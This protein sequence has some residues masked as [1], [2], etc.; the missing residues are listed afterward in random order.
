MKTKISKK[1][2][3]LIILASPFYLDKGSS[4]RARSN[5]IAWG[6][7]FDNVDLISYPVGKSLK[8]R[9]VN[10]IRAKIPGYKQISAGPSIVKVYADILLFF[11]SIY[12]ILKNKHDLV[13]GEDFEGGFLGKILAI[14]FHKKFIY[15]MYNPL[16]ENIKPYSSKPC[17][18]CVANKVDKF[19]EK[20]T[21]NIAFEWDY[22]K[23]R[24][25]TLYPGKNTVVVQDAFPRE[26][27]LING[28]NGKRYAF[29]AGNFKEYQGIKFFLRSFKLFL[30][31]GGNLDLVLAGAH[32]AETKKYAKDLG[33]L[34]KVNFVGN[35]DL[36]RT[37]Y[38]IKK[39]S[40]CILPR[41]VDG[42]PGI[43]ALH[44][45]SQGKPIL[46]TNLTCNSKMIENTKTGLLVPVSE[47]AMSE[48][49]KKM[50]EDK[51]FRD[52]LENNIRKEKIAQQ[53]KANKGVLD[54]VNN[55]I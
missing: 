52:S 17:V 35:K 33:I 46:A 25:D 45:F 2:K 3:V 9:H 12:L 37:N 54:L 42:P 31:N 39:S 41:T 19:L 1:S 50:T 21:H 40:F 29:Y 51:E 53:E 55:F 26:R 43:K 14:I 18:L 30:S 8:I 38:L 10:H 15:S 16:S 7:Y 11:H 24:V 47:K 44:Y 20:N 22:E 27:T 34:K 28:Y 36:K 13:I 5:M 48:G 6:S 32:Y 4:V 23:E 49:I